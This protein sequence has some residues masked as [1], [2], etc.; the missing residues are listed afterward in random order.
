[1]DNVD[2]RATHLTNELLMRIES[3]KVSLKND[4]A[5]HDPT[6]KST[7]NVYWLTLEEGYDNHPSDIW[8]KIKD[9]ME[10]MF[11]EELHLEVD[12]KAKIIVNVHDYNTF[13]VF[14]ASV[15]YS[16]KKPVDKLWLESIH[17]HANINRD[18]I[19]QSDTCGCFYCLEVFKSSEID[20]WADNERTAICPKCGIDSLIPSA[21][22]VPLTVDLLQ[23]MHNRFF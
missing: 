3:F 18:L 16:T 22:G 6:T 20:E 14:T 10:T 23:E 9:I 2:V 7:L 1:M 11:T 13:A 15:S 19:N 8:S 4:I 12:E 21:A 17:K 5:T